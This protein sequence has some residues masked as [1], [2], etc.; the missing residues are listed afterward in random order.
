RR[1]D[2]GPG[3]PLPPASAVPFRRFATYADQMRRLALVLTV[4]LVASLMGSP[5]HAAKPSTPKRF[6][7]YAFDTCVAPPNEVMDAWN[8]A[9]PYAVVGIYTSGVSRYCDDSK[10]PH[11][12]PAWVKRQADRGWR[13]MPIHVGLQAPCFDATSNKRRM[14]T[15]GATARQQARVEAD[16]AVS[17]AAHFGFAKGNT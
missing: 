16:E 7:G 11:L 6:T 12:S 10:Q 14:S 15:N 4:L 2:P 17:R 3:H 8:V 9:S 5:A 13:F 1:F